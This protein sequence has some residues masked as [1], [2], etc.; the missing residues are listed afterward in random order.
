MILSGKPVAEKIYESLKVEV[1]TLRQKGIKPA[2]AVV[3]VGDD[4][5]S[6]MYV[7][8]KEEKANELGIDFQLFHFSQITLEEEMVKIIKK[9]NSNP[10][11]HG[12]IVQLPLPEKFNVN[13]ILA[14]ISPTKDVDHLNNGEYLPPT[15]MSVIELLDYYKINLLDKKIVLVG[16]GKLVGKPLEEILQA[17]GL[18]PVVCDSRTIDLASKTMDADVIISGVGVP[19]LIKPEMV[20]SSVIIVD[21]GTAEASGKTVGDVDSSVYEKVTA[22]S[23]V[24]GGVGPITVAGLMKNLVEAAKKQNL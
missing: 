14:E 1:K 24:P 19:N 22:Y 9:I 11:M 21:A 15:A 18:K 20:K 6:L 23:P 4:P 2:L 10:G 16:Y 3:L 17:K 7:K 5:A 12:L 13:K 8:K